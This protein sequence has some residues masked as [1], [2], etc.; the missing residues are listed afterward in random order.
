MARNLTP[1]HVKI[2]RAY[3]AA[4][5]RVVAEQTRNDQ[6]IPVAI[7][8]SF[9]GVVLWGDHDDNPTTLEEIAKRLGISPTTLSTHLRYLGD[10][11]RA[12]KEGLGLVELENYVL[13][14]RMKVVKLSRKGRAL[15]DQLAYIL[16]GTRPNDNSEPSQ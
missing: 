12:G 3:L 15:A 14:R 10:H 1:Q 4:N 6:Y 11:Y 2:F 13:N 8:N 7:L 16:E 9:L 5:Q